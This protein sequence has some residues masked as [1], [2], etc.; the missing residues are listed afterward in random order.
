MSGLDRFLTA[1]APVYDQVLSELAAGQKRSHWMWFIFP[2]LRGLGHSETA[3]YY[4]LISLEEACAYQR[5]P[6]LGERLVQCTRLA[7]AHASRAL[8]ALFPAPD[9]LKFHSCMTLFYYAAKQTRSGYE[10]VFDQ[11]LMRWFSGQEDPNTI[12]LLR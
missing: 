9:H 5:H 2:Q 10:S 12:A 8:T 11:A 3:H 7:G 1:Q 6:V 4:G